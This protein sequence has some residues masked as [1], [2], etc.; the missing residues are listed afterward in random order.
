L[1]IGFQIQYIFP[2]QLIQLT[3]ITLFFMVSSLSTYETFAPNTRFSQAICL[4]D[5]GFPAH[6]AAPYGAWVDCAAH[7]SIRDR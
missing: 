3:K 2:S 7:H 1:E 6:I 4:A 5:T